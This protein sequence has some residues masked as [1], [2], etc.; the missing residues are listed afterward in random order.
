MDITIDMVRTKQDTRDFVRLPRRL[1][2][3]DPLW[4]P[5]I[6]W[7]E[8]KAYEKSRNPI[9]RQSDHILCLA[10][11]AGQVVGRNLVYIDHAFNRFNRSRIGFFGAF[12]SIADPRVGRLL[13]D[14]AADWLRS[15]GMRLIRGPIHP[16]AESWGFVIEGYDKPPV[17]MSP[18]NPPIY[19]DFAKA[20]GF[21]KAKDLWV[22][23]G[24]AADGYTIPPRFQSYYER[25][26]RR[27]PE[28]S[29]RPLDLKRLDTE[30]RHIWEL[31]NLSYSGNWGYVPL[32]LHVLQDMV[33]RLKPIVDTDAVWFVE[34]KGRPVGY[35]L[36][37]PDLNV[38]LRRISGR[39]FPFGWF[40]ILHGSR[41][42]KDYRLFGLAVHP[43][44]QNLGLDALLYV[45]LANALS[46]RGIRL[47]ANYILEDNHK[48]RNALEKLDLKRIKSYRIY[49]KDLK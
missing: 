8:R 34:S 43:D 36:G 41:R 23:E 46:P 10:R 16:V 17:Y 4:A 12:E 44:H 14:Q 31:S 20:A 29:I 25:F 35:C 38:I 49:E 3:D 18:H 40:K 42:L 33:H 15:R 30:A 22:Y 24:N 7:E 37:F 47:E 11:S 27:H 26:M 6:W 28:I 21:S 1:Y 2:R 5:P 9:L 13:L 45:H 32:D 48:I 39:L 19:N